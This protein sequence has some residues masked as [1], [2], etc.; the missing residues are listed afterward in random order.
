MRTFAVGDIHGRFDCLS[1]ALDEIERRA[2]PARIIFLGDY[3][4]RGPQSKEIVETLMRGPRRVGDEWICLKGNHECM[5]LETIGETSGDIRNLD[6]WL[7][8]GGD[9]TLASFGGVI[10]KPV[11][12]WCEALPVSY[13]S[14]HHFFVHAGVL[15]GVPLAEQVPREMLWIRDS[16]L[17]CTD[18]F[19]KHIVHGHT[20]QPYDHKLAAENRTNLDSGAYF[21][22][23]LSVGE[24]DLSKPGGPRSIFTT[25]LE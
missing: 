11:L 25:D 20:P 7:R 3:I 15:P 8:N 19:E 21:T 6:W 24:F 13:A 12:D 5:M 4:D 14:E 23:R 17:D 22:G 10:P 16:F 9:A 18:A 2:T 1:R